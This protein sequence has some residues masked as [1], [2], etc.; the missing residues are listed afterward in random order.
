MKTKLIL[1][2]IVLIAALPSCQ[3]DLAT[4]WTGTYNGTVGISNTFSRV[5]VTK[6][7][8]TTIKMELQSGALGT[9]YTYATVGNGKVTSNTVTI[10]EDGSVYG[11][12]GTY[13]F[14]GGG[15]LNG[16]TLTVTGQ[17]TQT[18]ATTLLYTFTGSK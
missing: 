13:H 4:N 14:S 8:N 16:N 7:N 10:N 2:A 12:T 1:I 3:K 15:T 11:Y 6:V 9:Y 18:G 17:A 5:V